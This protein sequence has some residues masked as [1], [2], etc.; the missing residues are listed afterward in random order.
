M[1]NK[2]RVI[3]FMILFLFV[4]PGSNANERML[5]DA[6]SA[7]SSGDKD[8]IKK[9]I[10]QNSD[11]DFK[12]KLLWEAGLNKKVEI[13]NILLDRGADANYQPENGR[14]QLVN[15]LYIFKLQ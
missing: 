14:L 12:N 3:F 6:M 5:S 2:T 15:I 10:T 1:S 11:Q 13:V 7:V 8:R 4:G 9:I